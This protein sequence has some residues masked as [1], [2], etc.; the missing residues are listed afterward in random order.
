MLAVDGRD[1]GRGPAW[2]REIYTDIAGPVLAD[3]VGRAW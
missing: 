2:E 1:P 3:Q